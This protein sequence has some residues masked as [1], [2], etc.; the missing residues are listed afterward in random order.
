MHGAL[1]WWHRL[2][3]LADVN[4]LLAAKPAR[5]VEL[6]IGGAEARGAGRAATQAL[7]ALPSAAG[8]A[9]TR[10]AN[11]QTSKWQDSPLAG[12]NCIERAH[13]RTG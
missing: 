12:D 2:K 13:G 11:E 3:W 7:P 5:E 8:N 10:S 6:L 1:H 4:A 9:P